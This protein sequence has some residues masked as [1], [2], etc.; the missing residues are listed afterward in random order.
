MCVCVQAASKDFQAI[1]C[2]FARQ[3]FSLLIA[4]N[5]YV[6]VCVCVQATPKD[7]MEEVLR[8][9]G[10]ASKDQVLIQSCYCMPKKCVS[11]CL[12][13]VEHLLQ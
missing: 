8:A 6:C 4:Y 9:G 10:D 3:C 7:Y 5:V 12:Q 2:C 1:V 13:R 11:F